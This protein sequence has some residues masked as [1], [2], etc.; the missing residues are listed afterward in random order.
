MCWRAG[1]RSGPT[2]RCGSDLPAAMQTIREI[3]NPRELDAA[4]GDAFPGSKIEITGSDGY[5]ELEMLQHGLMRRLSYRRSHKTCRRGGSC[6]K[7]SSAR[8]LSKPT[9]G[10]P[11]RGR[12]DDREN[13]PTIHSYKKSTSAVSSSTACGMPCCAERVRSSSLCVA[14]RYAPRWRARSI[15]RLFSGKRSAS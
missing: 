7:R 14:C 13:A 3:G 4:I 10:P 12:R 9:S 1:R 6:W 15:M 2:R 11:A 8:L 5:F